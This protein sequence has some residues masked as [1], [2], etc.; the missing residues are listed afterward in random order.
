M[1][2]Y[3]I[4]LFTV[5][6]VIELA[7]LIRVGQY[8]GAFSTLTVVILTGVTGAYLAR[9]QGLITLQKIQDDINQGMM[10][11]DKLFDGVLILC[12]GILLITPGFLTDLAGFA[13]LIPFTRN[14]FKGWL[15]RKIERMISQGRVITINNYKSF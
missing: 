13:G 5:I 6:P 1:L 4:F 8:I 7:L 10:P 14:L 9:M 3:L 12:C 11:A 15:K 2:G